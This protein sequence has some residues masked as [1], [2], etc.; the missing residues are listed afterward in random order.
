MPVTVDERLFDELQFN[1][2]DRHQWRERQKQIAREPERAMVRLV[3]AAIAWNAAG[4]TNGPKDIEDITRTVE[5]AVEQQLR[6]NMYLEDWS[7][8]Y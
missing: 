8:G 5:Y 4:R 1:R 7:S 3:E 6:V 2:K